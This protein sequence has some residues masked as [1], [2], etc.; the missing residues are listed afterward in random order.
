[1]PK[2][3]I[4]SGFFQES[5]IQGFSFLVFL[6]EKKICFIKYFISKNGLYKPFFENKIILN[7]W[8]K[9]LKKIK[10]LGKS[11][12]NGLFCKPSIIFQ[13]ILC[14]SLP[15]ELVFI[16]NFVRFLVKK[17]NFRVFF[18]P[19]DVCNPVLMPCSQNINIFKKNF[20]WQPPKNQLAESRINS[21]F[22]GL[23]THIFL[24]F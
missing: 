10:N 7:A 13:S 5:K 12:D 15:Q 21:G 24:K 4:L 23:Y 2:S 1:M 18:Y 11:L 14:D 19:C 17:R 22:L 6:A 20:W 9:I 16:A 3:R 8:E